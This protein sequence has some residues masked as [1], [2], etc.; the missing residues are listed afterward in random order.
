MPRKSARPTITYPVCVR[1]LKSRKDVRLRHFFLCDVCTTVWARDAFAGNGPLYAG[2]SIEGYCLLCNQV[3][4]VRMRTWFLCDICARVA[5]SI[6]RNHVAEQ[7]IID[8]WAASIS[9]RFPELLL[10]QNDISALLPRRG[11]D[12]SAEGPIDF[13]VRNGESGEI[14][15]GIENKT[16]RSAV[17][18]MSQFQLDIS[19][20]NAITNDMR[21]LNVPA[22]IIHA[23]VLENWRPPTLGFAIIGLWWTDIYRMAEHFQAVSTRRDEMRGAA[24]FSKRAF[25]PMESFA[26]QLMGKKT[27]ALVERF[28]KDGIPTLYKLP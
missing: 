26:D 12:I 11:T 15:L 16:G 24:Y 28:R 22:Y 14:V 5:G 1:H 7:A 6:G 19:D 8:F 3:K 17:Y 21:K 4:T 27:L 10:T 13:L 20:C 2:E 25:L 9:P 23:Q 18:D